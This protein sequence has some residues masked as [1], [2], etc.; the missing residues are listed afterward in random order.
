MAR[1]SIRSW[2]LRKEAFMVFV[3]GKV[4]RYL[5]SFGFLYFL[6]TETRGLIGYTSHEVLFFAA[7]FTLIDTIA[8]FLFRSVYTF[9][10]LVVTGDFD[11][12]LLKPI[13]PLFR[14]LMGG[15]DPMDLVTIPP[16]IA[17][18]IYIGS[19][20]NPTPLSIF[21]YILLVLNG[22][23]IYMTF[24]I[25]VLSLGVITL[26]IDHTIMVFRDMASMGRLPIDIYKEPFK[27]LLTFVVPVGIIFSIPSKAMMGLLG[28]AGIFSSLLFGAAL[29]LLSLKF[30]KFALRKYTSASS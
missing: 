3:L 28:P 24:H 16:I 10:Q 29:F 12:V 26:E 11:L 13:S 1:N 17:L 23:L 5:F 8:Q 19:F 30:W 7:T 15:A 20:L 2:F 25:F 21:Y 27:S 6:L 18:V 22:I 14:S 4:V 9:R